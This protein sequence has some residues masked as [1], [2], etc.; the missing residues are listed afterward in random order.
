MAFRNLPS[1]SGGNLLCDYD[2]VS[3]AGQF[4]RTFG[5]GAGWSLAHGP[6]NSR[7]RH[8]RWGSVCHLGDEPDRAPK[9]RRVWPALATLCSFGICTRICPVGI[10]AAYSPAAGIACAACFLLWKYRAARSAD[11]ALGSHVVIGLPVCWSG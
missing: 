1:A 2:S 11:C 3:N 6:L 9:G 8:L 10:S 4:A 7:N 5:S